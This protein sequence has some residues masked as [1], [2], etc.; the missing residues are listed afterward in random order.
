[1]EPCDV[2]VAGAGPTGLALACDLAWRGVRVRIVDRAPEPSPY[3]RAVGV[4]P[5]TLEL[6]E[7]VGAAD[8]IVARG[9]AF[10]SL[11]VYGGARRLGALEI[12]VPSRYPHVVSLPQGDT[13]RILAARLAAL[14]GRVERGTELAEVHPR[15]GGVRAV[16]AR[17]DAR[18]TVEV[19]WLVSCEGAHSVTR[20]ALGI[21]FRGRAY[22]ETFA[23]ADAE[24]AGIGWP[25]GHVFLS[26]DGVFFLAPMPGEQRFRVVVS[27]H[28]SAPEQAP[29]AD[30]FGRWLEARVR[31]AV[32]DAALLG[33]GWTS[34]F[35]IH[36]R[37]VP[38]LRHG[39]VLLAGDAAHI[40]SPAGGQGM[41]AGI[42]DALNLGW[43]LAL[44]IQGRAGERLLD[45]YDAERLPV[46]R[47]ILKATDRFTRAGLLRWPPARAVR[48][49]VL[50]ALLASRA[51]RGTLQLAQ[52]GLAIHYR[53]SPAVAPD[54][55]PAPR[56]GERAPDVPFAGGRLYDHL[57]HPGFTLLLFPPADHTND[58][59]AMGDAVRARFGDLVRPLLAGEL[60]DAAAAAAAY[61]G[62]RHPAV[63]VRPD[64]YVA[65]RGRTLDAGPLLAFLA[66]VLG[67]AE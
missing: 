28:G 34:Y 46:S 7:N 18:E 38:A 61:A 17:G 29:N 11:N 33:V 4:L 65:W 56:P 36:R 21:P 14:G 41:N 3:S 47:A 32:P 6:L 27:L 35:R 8:E 37:M 52:T 5:R 24:I 13:E 15:A 22:A 43:K 12:E 62:D 54:R 10:S 31:P 9:V 50:G 60:P 42:Q 23:L 25:R 59:R 51:A 67:A 55:G 64:R 58:A 63:L 40:H 66:R 1:M 26:A 30:D 39:R 45:S 53:G 2:L 57:R 16:L 19:P 20:R 48:D 44:V 49:R